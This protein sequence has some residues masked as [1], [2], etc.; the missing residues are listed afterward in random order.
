[1]SLTDEFFPSVNPSVS[2]VFLVVNGIVMR[3]FDSLHKI[4]NI[5]LIV[6]NVTEKK[7]KDFL[8][9]QFI[10]QGQAKCLLLRNDVTLKLNYKKTAFFIRKA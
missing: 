8:L 7:K 9:P 4:L 5:N 2:C 6:V 3:S 1:M 10:F